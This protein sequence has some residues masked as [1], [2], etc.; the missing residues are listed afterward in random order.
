M[1]G[2]SIKTISYFSSIG[3]SIGSARASIAPLPSSTFACREYGEV[4]HKGLGS[5]MVDFE[6]SQ[7]HLSRCI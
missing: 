5:C 1:S 3:I 7:E 6:F 4:K 2:S